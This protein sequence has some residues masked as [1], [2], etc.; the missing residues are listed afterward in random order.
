MI[1]KCGKNK[2]ITQIVKKLQAKNSKSETIQE[3]PMCVTINFDELYK[4]CNT[5]VMLRKKKTNT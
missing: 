4:I 2:F 3:K 1:Q 5:F